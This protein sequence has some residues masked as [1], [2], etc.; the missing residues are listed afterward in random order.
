MKKIFTLLTAFAVLLSLTACGSKKAQTQTTAA[1]QPSSTEST[2]TTAATQPSTTESTSPTETEPEE[3]FEEIVLVDD[4]KITLKI[5]DVTQDPIWGYTWN[6]FVENKT[7]QELM[8]TV[9]N[10]SVNG[11]MCDPF[12]ATAVDAGKKSNSTV[13][14]LDST[15]EENGIEKVEEITFTLRV[16][17]SNDWL[18]EDVVNETFTVNF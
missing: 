9:Q 1:T 16:Y 10:V 6:V 13:S 14:W 8:F 11:F 15:L 4:E 7:E 2:S 3:T 12:W 17:D 5:T 18:A